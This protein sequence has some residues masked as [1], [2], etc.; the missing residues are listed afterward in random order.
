MQKFWQT[1]KWGSGEIRQAPI[2]NLAPEQW[3]SYF[4][5]QFAAMPGTPMNYPEIIAD[6][7]LTFGIGEIETALDA[8]PTGRA[9]GPDCIPDDLFRHDK[10][11]WL[12]YIHILASAIARGAPIPDSWRGAEIIPI[13]KKGDHTRPSNY[14]PISLIDTIQKIMA[15][16]VLSRINTWI[17][18]CDIL[19]TLQAGY[20]PHISTIDQVFRFMMIYRSTVIIA[21]GTLYAA[22]IDLKSTFDLVP[23]NTLWDSL[24]ELGMP[25][26]LLRIIVKLHELNYAQVRWSSQGKLTDRFPVS[27]GVRQ[28]CVLAPT[29]FSLF[30]NRVVTYFS[31]YPTDAPTLAGSKVP[32]LMFPDDTLILSKTQSGLQ[33]ALDRFTVFCND[34]ELVVNVDKTKFM[35]LHRNKTVKTQNSE[36]ESGYE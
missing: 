2:N 7:T 34:H 6:T 33:R 12:K 23:R 18:E 17:G 35:V 32:L 24:K 11:N 9:P 3:V 15:R 26:E 14:R 1:V 13:Y 5:A 4:Q 27:K 31:T 29:L 10:T 20:R 22:F 8:I 36:R 25:P 21:G 30:I 19:S 28:G 16:F